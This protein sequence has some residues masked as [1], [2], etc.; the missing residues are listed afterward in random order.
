MALCRLREK[1]QMIMLL[2]T[3][4]VF[5]ASSFPCAFFKNFFQAFSIYEEEIADSRA[6]LAAI[7][8]LIGNDHLS[9]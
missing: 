3:N 9:R 5:V 2:T 4:Y 6:Q 1:K 8:L 7:S